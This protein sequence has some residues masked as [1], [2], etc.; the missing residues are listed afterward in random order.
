MRCLLRTLGVRPAM[1][2][3]EIPDEEPLAVPDGLDG[4][5][6]N[7][8]LL[9]FML[10]GN[11]PKSAV[12]EQLRAGQGLPPGPAGQEAIREMYAQVSDQ[13]ARIRMEQGGEKPVF[14]DLALDLGTCRTTA[15]LPLLAG[16]AGWR[17]VA[18]RAVK[19]KGADMLRLW[20]RHLA[21]G[22]AGLSAASVHVA[23]DDIF[24]APEV[25]KEQAARILRDLVRLRMSGMSAPLP[26]FP[27]ASL[28]YARR[29]FDAKNG[30]M[31]SALNEAR[32]NWL[33]GLFHPRRAGRPV[34]ARRI[35]GRRTRLGSLRGRDR[36]RVRPAAWRRS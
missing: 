25:S 27:R 26:L 9:N 20:V 19:L 16:G 18:F 5:G 24:T 33:G 34:P 6:L 11:P 31:E 32:K 12:R 29:R 23:R 4:F 22:A 36:S 21:A 2:D 28:I 3:G 30:D 7:Q 8:D 17:M 14:H 10:A 1:P 35:P 13:A 15:K